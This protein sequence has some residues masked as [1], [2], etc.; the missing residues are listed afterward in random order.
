MKNDKSKSIKKWKALWAFPVVAILLFAF[1][2]PKYEYANDATE[3]ST[4]DTQINLKGT[5]LDSEGN[6]LHGTSIA[7]YRRS[8]GHILKGTI[9]DI[10]GGFSLSNISLD[11]EVVFSFV[12]FKTQRIKPSKKMTVTMEQ[13]VI[14]ISTKSINKNENAP[15]P[16]SAAAAAESA[17]K[18][19][20]PVEV[21]FVVEDLPKFKGGKNQ[22]N[23]FI[24]K[25]TANTKEK[26]SV[27]VN[28][29]V[30]EKGIIQD[31]TIVNSPSKSLSEKAERIMKS[32][33]AWEP[34]KQRGKPVKTKCNLEIIF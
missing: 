10:N 30:T 6:G 33:P 7:V 9:S 22:L 28:F 21:F 17:E 8:N 16:P 29:T 5:V 19:E 2:E 18:E 4:S 26:G 3:S 1:A 20:G 25:A 11:D 15:P 13:S 12:G 23:K 31:I 27:S 24:D 34:G 32:M 14:P